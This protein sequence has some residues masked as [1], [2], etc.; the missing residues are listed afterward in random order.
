MAA[1]KKK[2]VQSKVRRPEWVEFCTTN[3]GQGAHKDNSK[4]NRKVKHKRCNDGE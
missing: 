3:H 4:Y 2:Q 1:K